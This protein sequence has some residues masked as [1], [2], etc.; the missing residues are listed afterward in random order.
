MAKSHHPVEAHEINPA[1]VQS[2]TF[3]VHMGIALLSIVDLFTPLQ[4]LA[5]RWMPARSSRRISSPGLRYVGVRPSCGGRQ[6]ATVQASAPTARPLRVV[7]MVDAQ[8][9]GCHQSRV[10]I[11]GRMAD[12]CAELDRLVALE[13]A[14][15]PL[16]SNHTH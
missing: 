11:S 6:S 16:Q 13:A 14:G 7:R 2:L 3:G 4:S 1:Y 15:T 8:Q 10:V 5:S 12:V 9:P